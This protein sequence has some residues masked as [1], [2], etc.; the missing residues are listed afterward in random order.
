MARRLT[1]GRVAHLRTVARIQR[2]LQ[3]TLHSGLVGLG[4]LLT[5]AEWLA[6]AVVRIV[7]SSFLARLRERLAALEAELVRRL[8][9]EALAET[10]LEQT[11]PDELARLRIGELIRQIEE[12]GLVAVRLQLSLI[13]DAGMT[14]EAIATIGQ[15]TGLT[16]RQVA[17]VERA[18]RAALNA[19]ATEAAAAHTAGRVRRRLIDQRAKLIA[20]TETVRYVGD[21]VQERGEAVAAAGGRVERQWVSARDEAVDAGNPIGPCK[22]NDDG[23]RRS[24]SEVFPSGH[25][26][27]PAHPG[28]RC[29]LELWVDG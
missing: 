3:P 9:A 23:K 21:L 17:Q 14:P 24:L 13:A 27:P 25:D 10:L 19:G 28:C 1:A 26:R 7:P 6:A 11:S 8:V 4:Q 20:R 15:A 2:R 12:E 29:L 22:R 16:T 5:P 18:R